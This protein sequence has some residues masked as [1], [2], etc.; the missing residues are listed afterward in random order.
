MNASTGVVGPGAF[1]NEVEGAGQGHP[2]ALSRP[3]TSSRSCGRRRR[4]RSRGISARCS[5]A[6]GCILQT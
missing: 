5:A 1:A 4:A 6:R 3:R 2:A